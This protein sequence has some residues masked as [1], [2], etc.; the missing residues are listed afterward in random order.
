MRYVL[1]ALA[2]VL[3]VGCSGRGEKRIQETAM[4]RSQAM[5]APD[6]ALN[7]YASYELRPIAM[8]EEIKADDGKKQRALELQGKIQERVQPLLNEWQAAGG[9][10]R[11][12]TLAIEPRLDSLRIISAVNRAFAGAFSGNSSIGLDLAL[13]DTSSN[14]VVGN[15]RLD[16]SSNAFAGKWSGGNSDE[17]LLNYVAET[18]RQYLVLNYGR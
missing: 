6:R 18:V 11:S 2:L 17:N 5:Q 9:T 12:G 14:Q 8:S 15:P 7:G 10:G 16:M 4:E 13:I 1:I 3:A